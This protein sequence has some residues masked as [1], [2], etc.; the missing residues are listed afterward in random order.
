MPAGEDKHSRTEKPTQRR[1]REARREGRV[2]RTPEVVTWMVVLVGSYLVQHT[3]QASY[4]LSETLWA[5]VANAI[6][7]PELA[8]DLKLLGNAAG[9][10]LSALA[11]ALLG[12]MTLALVVNLAQTRG[13]ITFQ[14]LKPS[15][16]HLNPKNGFKRIVSPT[17]LWNLG[18]QLVR[19]SLL[20]LVVWQTLHALFPLITGNNPLSS[21]ALASLVGSRAMSLIREVAEISLILSVLDYIVQYRKTSKQLKMTKEEVREEHK[22]TDGNPVMRGAIRRRQRQIARNRMLAAVARADAVVLNPTHFAVALLYVR[23]KGAPKVVAKGTDLLALRIREEASAH[24]VPLVE[25]PPLARA[26][27]V[28]CQLEQ[29]IPPELYEAVARL[30]TFI[31][32]LKASGRLSRIDGA[33]HRPATPL[34]T[35]AGVTSY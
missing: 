5:D 7:K 15:L 32:G 22:A 29:E 14:P 34:L 20:S 10:T 1:K 16:K 2:A 26:L 28:A 25:D 3:F 19:V 6:R 23:G 24:G 30:L 18:K 8:A 21:P 9:G 17:S 33:P 11:P 31:Y 27:Y 35:G 4:A 12:T 13:L